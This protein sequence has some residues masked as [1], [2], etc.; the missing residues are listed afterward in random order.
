REEN[1]SRISTLDI[2]SPVNIG[3]FMAS[4]DVFSG[5]LFY[6]SVSVIFVNTWP[7]TDQDFLVLLC[8]FNSFS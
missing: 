8:I 2:I 4:S 6:K 1:S 7:N 5:K 3:P